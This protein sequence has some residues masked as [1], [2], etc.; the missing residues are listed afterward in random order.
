[1]SQFSTAGDRSMAISQI[2][3]GSSLSLIASSDQPDKASWLPWLAIPALCLF[4]ITIAVAVV[5]AVSLTS[6]IEKTD[7]D[8]YGVGGGGGGGGGDGGDGR[9]VIS[10]GIGTRPTSTDAMASTSDA[11][12]PVPPSISST[13]G[14]SALTG[15][16]PT[17]HMPTGPEPTMTVPTGIPVGPSVPVTTTQ[18]SIPTSPTTTT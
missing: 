16:V 2:G 9:R 1:E 10:V 4:F 15:S 13:P 7:Y 3:D 11:I 12:E 18:V 6:E 8:D 14:A 17:E 5:A